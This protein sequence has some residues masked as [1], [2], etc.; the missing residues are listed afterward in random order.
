[1]FLLGL[2]QNINAQETYQVEASTGW[3]FFNLISNPDDFLGQ[4]KGYGV[5]NDLTFWLNDKANHRTNFKVGLGYTNFI[6]LEFSALRNVTSSSYL[7][8]KTGFDFDLSDKSKLKTSFSTYVLL[9]KDFQDYNNLQRR[10]FTNLDIGFQRKIGDKWSLFF[11]TPITLRYMYKS[12]K[13]AGYLGNNGLVTADANVELIGLNIGVNYKIGN[14]KKDF[15]PKLDLSKSENHVSL[16]LGIGYLF[17]DVINQKEDVLNYYQGQGLQSNLN[18]W[19]NKS[20]HEKIDAKFGLGYTNYAHLNYEA[21][22]ASTSS[23]LN[24]R[25]GSDIQTGIQPIQ[26]S[27]A[28]SN[29]LLL[30]KELQDINQFQK[31]IFTNIDIGANI[32]LTDKLS[33]SVTTPLTIFPMIEGYR[34]GYYQNNEVIMMDNAIVGTTGL[35]IGLNYKIK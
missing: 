29:Y 33:L 10:F 16:E 19:F 23:Y 20:I 35:N 30:H 8:L 2:N 21:I 6:P 28:I 22:N 5:Q 7:G 9:N 13:G 32:K 11:T 14:N 1:M 4:Y 17:Y 12:Q 34:W 26:L 24:F 15:L 27:F 18:V 31:R 3:M 25:F